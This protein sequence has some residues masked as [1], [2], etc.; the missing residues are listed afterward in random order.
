VRSERHAAEAAPFDLGE[1]HRQRGGG[2]A[3]GARS[4][5]VISVVQEQPAASDAVSFRAIRSGVMKR[6]Q[7][8]PH[9]DHR[10]GAQPRRRAIASPA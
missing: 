7:S 4:A 9:C 1:D 8:R 3:P 2:A 10:T 6:R 5:V